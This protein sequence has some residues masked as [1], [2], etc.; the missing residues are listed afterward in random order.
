[1][2]LIKNII[3]LFISAAFAPVV[4]LILIYFG[5]RYFF[6]WLFGYTSSIHARTRAKGFFRY[7]A[8]IY[9]LTLYSALSRCVPVFG[10]HMYADYRRWYAV[11]SR[12]Q[13]PS[14]PFVKVFDNV[15]IPVADGMST[16][17]TVFCPSHQPVWE[18]QDQERLAS[19]KACPVVVMRTPYGRVNLSVAGH[20]FAERGFIVVAQDTRG[21]YDS[22]GEFFPVQ[23][24]RADGVATVR[25]VANQPWCNGNIGAFGIS[26]VGLTSWAAAGEYTPALKAIVPVMASSSIYDVIYPGGE[27]AVCWDL[28]I[29]WMY[30]VFAYPGIPA[31]LRWAK[32]VMA[33]FV[34]PDVLEQLPISTADERLLGKPLPFFQEGL[35]HP[36]K[37]SPFWENKDKLAEITDGIPSV[38]LVGGWHDF[39]LSEQINDFHHCQRVLPNNKRPNGHVSIVIGPWGHWD[40]PLYSGPA[41]EAAVNFFKKHL[42]DGDVPSSEP[43]DSVRLFVYGANRWYSFRDG[44][45]KGVTCPIYF[46]TCGGLSAPKLSGSQGHAHSDDI[47]CVSV[48]QY[49][50]LD[51]TPSAGG[52]VFDPFVNVRQDQNQIEM[53]RDV[54][55]FTSPPLT[56]Q[57]DIVGHVYAKVYVSA[58]VD[59][60]DV[61]VRFCELRKSGRSL[62]ICEG[63]VRVAAGETT[64]SGSEI[65]PVGDNVW[66]VKVPLSSCAIRI[67]PGN[68]LRV[69]VFSACHPRILRN[70]CDGQPLHGVQSPKPASVTIHHDKSRPSAVYLPICQ[71]ED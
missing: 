67:P 33:N 20:S 44:F 13:K 65:S 30:V 31:V 45:P 9:L 40:F 1:M 15:K 36:S 22:S 70:L 39:F 25:W 18:N 6:Q 63:I 35:M 55:V 37:H 56:D 71:L 54:L 43:E 17:S 66:C 26:Y 49:D 3:S 5:C 50:P 58:S 46:G 51:A 10:A 27:G 16:T 48:Y 24:E 52:P 19:E 28:M 41:T 61:G 14:H 12:I 21:R 62:N 7:V 4:G 53:R 42:N 47:Q 57:I 8:G 64:A 29:R 69:H 34:V 59:N 68:S 23:H 11:W 32:L 38:L 60:F 2:G